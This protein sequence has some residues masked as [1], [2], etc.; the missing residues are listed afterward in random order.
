MMLF[1]CTTMFLI[2]FMLCFIVTMSF[3]RVQVAAMAAIKE[4][5]FE[6]R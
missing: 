1:R 4:V 6:Q 5:A 3:H 2:W